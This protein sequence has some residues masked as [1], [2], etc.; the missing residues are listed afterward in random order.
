MASRRRTI[1]KGVY[2]KAMAD[3]VDNYNTIRRADFEL[4]SRGRG[5]GAGGYCVQRGNIC[6]IGRPA[7]GQIFWGDNVTLGQDVME[8]TPFSVATEVELLK[9]KLLRFK[10]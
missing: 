7:Q 10:S 6:P 8:T 3:I 5:G 9:T 4:C 2:D 1:Q